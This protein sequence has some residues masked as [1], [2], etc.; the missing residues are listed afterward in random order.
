ML[1]VTAEFPETRALRDVEYLLI[2]L[3]DGSAPSAHE[4]SRAIEFIAGSARPLLVHCAHGHGR[5]A[6][7]IAAWMLANNCRRQPACLTGAPE[8][9]QRSSGSARSSS[10]R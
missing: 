9:H 3:L 8:A 4:L 2:P 10:G 7:M 6:V 5:S 1:D